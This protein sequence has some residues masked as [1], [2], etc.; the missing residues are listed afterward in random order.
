MA[1]RKYVE[2]PDIGRIN[3]NGERVVQRTY[4]Q[5]E[6]DQNI[7][8]MERREAGEYSNRSRSASR[9]ER[10]KRIQKDQQD[11]KYMSTAPL[12]ALEEADANGEALAMQPF[13]RIGPDSTSMNGPVTM[14]RAMRGEIPVR[15]TN[16]KQPYYMTPAPTKGSELMDADGLK[17]SL[18]ANLDIEIELKASIRGDLTVSLYQ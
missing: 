14:A 11:G 9:R 16:A 3:K 4:E 10:R 12:K 5:H 18:E 8:K 1:T 7:Q 13:E 2:E 17:L 6:K 15:G